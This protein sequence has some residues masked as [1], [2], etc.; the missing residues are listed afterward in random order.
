MASKPKINLM[1]SEVVNGYACKPK[2]LDP[3]KPI[4]HY[5]SHIFICN[6]DRCAKAFK[7]DKAKELREILK[8]MGLHK[9]KNR[10]KVTRSGCY[11]ACRFRGVV[12][13]YENT[14]SNGFLPNNNIWLKHTHNYSKDK[15]KRLFEYLSNNVPLVD[16]DFE[17]IEQ[18]IYN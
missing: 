14:A 6:G 7:E 10:I 12:N 8:E 16:S 15:W 18:K 13:I 2:K 11:G 3:N 4:M 5:K 9:G 1:G 17:I